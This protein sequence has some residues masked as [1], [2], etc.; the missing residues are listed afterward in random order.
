MEQKEESTIKNGVN[1][2]YVSVIIVVLLLFSLLVVRPGL[3]GYGIYQDV[4]SS[5]YSLDEFA[6]NVQSLN[7]EMDNIKANLSLNQDFLEMTQNEVSSTKEELTSCESELKSLEIEIDHCQESDRIKE[8]LLASTN[9]KISA[10]V[11]EQTTE[12]NN[13]KDLCLDTI[14]KKEEEL[15]VI[16]A[17]YNSLVTNVARSICCKQRVDNP[18]ISAYD[19]VENRIVCLSSGSKPLSC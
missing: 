6:Q 8:E 13:A 18:E 11:E 16:E 5:G 7:T 12:I 4:Q 15:T 2:W 14:D 9:E 1:I 17:K 10:A 19:V 3:I